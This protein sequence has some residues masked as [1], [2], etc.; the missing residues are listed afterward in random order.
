MN[1]WEEEFDRQLGYFDN[2]MVALLKS[3]ISRIR[4][5]AKQEAIKELVERAREKAHGDPDMRGISTERIYID[6]LD[7]LAKEIMEKDK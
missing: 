2:P 4:Q 6:D 1:D 7:Q 5:E 3:F